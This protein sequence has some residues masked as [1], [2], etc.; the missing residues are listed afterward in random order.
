MEEEKGLKKF[1]FVN[2]I[3][4]ERVKLSVK[5]CKMFDV[6]KNIVNVEFSPCLLSM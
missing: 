2:I 5:T 3:I 4:T 6:V 1:C